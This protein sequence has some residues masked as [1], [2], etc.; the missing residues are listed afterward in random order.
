MHELLLFGQ[1]PPQRHDQVLKILAGIAAM[2]PHMLVE[3]H[4]IFKPRRPIVTK[5]GPK[6]GQSLSQV[7]A[8]QKQLQ[9]DLFYMQ[10]VGN[11]SN[12]T[13][14][15]LINSSANTQEDV[16]MGGVQS[17]ESNGDGV[18]GASSNK[19]DEKATEG[20]FKACPWSI[21]FR[22]IPEPSKRPVTSRLM[23]SIPVIDGDSL[24]AI[25]AMG[26]K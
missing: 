17:Q 12:L 23:A 22:D 26:Y 20:M 3:R 25:E 7:Q 11:M 6:P 4:L 14:S 24:R 5:E 16:P 2:Q 9:G 13:N 18:N 10:L 19:P 15:K 21:E 1:V 8:L